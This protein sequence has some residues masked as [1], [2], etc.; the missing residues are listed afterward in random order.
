MLMTIMTTRSTAMI[1][2]PIFHEPLNTG[3]SPRG[4]VPNASRTIW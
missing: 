4:L 3:G 2:P 1:T